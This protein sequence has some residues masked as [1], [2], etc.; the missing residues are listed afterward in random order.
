MLIKEIRLRLKLSQR[1]FAERFQIPI[2]TLRKW[3]QGE[4]RPSDYLINLF[5]LALPELNKNNKKI[6]N[7]KHCYFIN[8]E[9]KIIYDC[10]GNSIHYNVDLSDISENNLLIYL[11]QIF[12]ELYDS[13]RRLNLYLKKDLEYKIEWEDVND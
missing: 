3:E 7:E 1:E 13:Q 2:S 4:S 8:E 6:G 12:S 5:L 11:K 10:F 9:T